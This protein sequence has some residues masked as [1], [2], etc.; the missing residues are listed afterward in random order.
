MPRS[1]L[2]IAVIAA[3]GW[4][5]SPGAALAEG[6]SV[7]LPAVTLAVADLYYADTSGEEADQTAAHQEWLRTFASALQRDLSESGK[8]R[9]VPLNCGVEPCSARTD[10]LEL[11]KAARAAGVRLVVIGGVHKTSTLVQWGKIQIA[12]VEQGSVVFD[13]LLTFRGD[14]AL[15]WQ[16]AEAFAVREILAASPGYGTIAGASPRVKMAVFDF[17]LEDFSPAAALLVNRPMDIEQLKLATD[18]ARGLIAQSG[19]YSVIDVSSVGEAPAKAHELR[20]CDGCDAG[21]A[22]KLGADQ[23]LVGVVTRISMTDYAVT[24]K[25]RDARTGALVAVEQ[26]DL[27]MGANH[28]WNRGAAWLIKNRLLTK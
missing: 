16:K 7:P 28:S 9:I 19:G 3:L 18:T 13:Q 10:P 15:A 8:Y 27:R 22:R 17:E 26:T 23:S 1:M 24:F 20:N 14:T 25:L 2:A 11:Q 6:D 4:A 12:D 21:I 5:A